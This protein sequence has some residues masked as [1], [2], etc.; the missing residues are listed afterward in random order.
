MVPEVVAEGADL[1]LLPL[2]ALVVALPEGGQ[3]VRLLQPLVVL[4]HKDG[5]QQ[6]QGGEEHEGQH[7]QTQPQFH[8]LQV[9]G[10]VVPRG[11][12]GHHRHQGAEGHGRQKQHQPPQPGGQ[13]GRPVR[14]ALSGRQIQKPPDDRAEDPAGVEHEIIQ[15]RIVRVPDVVGVQQGAH[16]HDEAEKDGRHRQPPHPV[17]PGAG[18]E[19]G[20]EHREGEN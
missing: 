14:Q 4:Q 9:R 1:G 11:G 12:H 8:A 6:G 10:D 17:T 15:R 18:Q 2:E 19:H 3:L 20:E 16:R 13:P 5:V 7:R